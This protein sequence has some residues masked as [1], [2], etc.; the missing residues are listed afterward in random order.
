MTQI[1]DSGNRT[2]FETG[3]VRDIQQGKGRFDLMPLDVMSEVFAVEF[4]N[5]FEEGSIA[6]VLKSIAFFQRTGNIRW[7]CIAI[8]QYS[9]VRQCMFLFQLSCLTLQ[10]ISKTAH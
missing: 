4:A 6:D 9:T 1:I 10:G 2:E 5:E 3:A 7:L 8:V